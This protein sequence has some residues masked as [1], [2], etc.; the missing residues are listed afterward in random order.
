MPSR[1]NAD[2]FGGQE[3]A[4][5]SVDVYRDKKDLVIT[6]PMAGVK[7]DN[8][9]ISM[10]G[11]LLTVRGTRS[12]AKEIPEDDWYYREN[13]WGSFSRSIVLPHEVAVDS[14]KASLKNGV[15]EIRIPI[16]TQGKKM[17]VTWEE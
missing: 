17:K 16:S 4:Q 6:S 3:E 11:D 9:D 13:Y 8:L 5:L 15:L 12:Y 7:P 14:A 2:W 10:H 1:S